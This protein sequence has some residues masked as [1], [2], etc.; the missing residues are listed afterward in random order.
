MGSSKKGKAAENK[1][2]SR[3]RNGCGSP[4]NNLLESGGHHRLLSWPYAQLPLHKL[5]HTAER[6]REA[7]R[8]ALCSTPGKTG[9]EDAK[10]RR[11][12]QLLRNSPKIRKRH[13]Y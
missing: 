13:F 1:M 8:D 10:N 7:D 12:K 6:P 11:D 4:V 3:K 5:K 9:Q 2:H